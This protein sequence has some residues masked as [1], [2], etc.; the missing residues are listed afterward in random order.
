MK[1]MTFGLSLLLA[2]PAMAVERDWIGR[3]DAAAR[4]G[5]AEALRGC[6]LWLEAHD[7]HGSHGR[8]DA[9]PPLVIEA[10]GRVTLL[11]DLRE[12]MAGLRRM[13]LPPSRRL[14]AYLRL[15]VPMP[16]QRLHGLRLLAC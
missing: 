2:L 13:V 3:L 11:F 10:A 1:A 7:D 15:P 16:P 8:L 6:A 4:P 5:A 12:A 14:L 9:A